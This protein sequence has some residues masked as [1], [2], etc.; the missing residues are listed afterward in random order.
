[1]KIGKLLIINCRENDSRTILTNLIFQE[2]MTFIDRNRMRYADRTIRTT[3][4][5]V[6]MIDQIT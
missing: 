2:E 1:M 5:D 6:M 4:L 3:F